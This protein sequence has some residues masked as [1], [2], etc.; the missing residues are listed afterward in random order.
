MEGFAIADRMGIEQQAGVWIFGDCVVMEIPN[1]SDLH[2][3]RV[4][5]ATDNDSIVRQDVIPGDIEEMEQDRRAL[6]GGSAPTDGWE[7]GL[8]N[9]V[10]PENGEIVDGG[11]S[12]VQGNGNV[13]ETAYY[14]TVEEAVA[15]AESDWNHLSAGDKKRYSDRSKGARF[16]VLDR[17]G[18]VVRDFVEEMDRAIERQGFPGESEDRLGNMIATLSNRWG[19]EWVDS[20]YS[21]ADAWDGTESVTEISHEYD[22]PA[23]E[24]MDMLDALAAIHALR[25]EE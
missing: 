23:D 1:D 21:L 7:D 5:M 12:V 4:L 18:H 15:V 20:A 2:A 19:H 25:G 8:G 13:E 3:F 6:E 14:A 24:A 16:E 17:D 22:M 11:F 10:C 9:T